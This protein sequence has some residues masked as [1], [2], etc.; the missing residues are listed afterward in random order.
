MTLRS[1]P[2]IGTTQAGLTP[3]DSLTTGISA[4]IPW[5]K[6]RYYPERKRVRLTSKRYAGIGGAYIIWHWD[7]LKAEWRHALRD[8][9]NTVSVDDLFI[10]S[11][12][13]DDDDN[14]NSED[15]KQFEV[16]A[17]WPEGDE[18]KDATRRMSFD[19]EFDVIEALT[20]LVISASASRSP[21]ASLSPSSSVSPS[22]SPSAS[23]SPS[24]S[25]SPSSSVS[26]SI[27]PSASTSASTSPS[28]SASP[29]I[30][31]SAST[32]PSA[33]VSPS[34]SVSPSPSA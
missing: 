33:S 6:M 32:S 29:S 23:L 21:S 16:I 28:H 10:E 12:V 30:S 19:I 20:P 11:R 22:I 14:D 3:L 15:W 27:S 18:E 24:A 31:P 7:F 8:Y 1:E 25:I 4:Q 5:P 34:S 9:I 2:C 26:P 13:N 17:T